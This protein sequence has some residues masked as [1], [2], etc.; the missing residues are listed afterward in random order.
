MSDT[1]FARFKLHA[2]FAKR[3]LAGEFGPEVQTE[4]EDSIA[5]TTNDPTY[6]RGTLLE[7]YDPWEL[8]DFG[9]RGNHQ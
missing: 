6:I 1:V 8:Y 7:L 5:E 3:A 4:I 9:H 2:S